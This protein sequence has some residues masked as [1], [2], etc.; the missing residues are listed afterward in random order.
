MENDG[1]GGEEKD[2]VETEEKRGGREGGVETKEKRGKK[3]GMER[4]GGVLAR[5]VV[6]STMGRSR[7]E[8]NAMDNTITGSLLPAVAMERLVRHMDLMR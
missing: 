5:R 6:R 7:K 8:H 3:G 4:E 1:V 2:V